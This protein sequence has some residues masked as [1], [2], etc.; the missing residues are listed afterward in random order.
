[1]TSKSESYHIAMI[2]VSLIVQAC[3]S[4]F[5]KVGNL[6]TIESVLGEKLHN[7]FVFIFKLCFG[8]SCVFPVGRVGHG[9]KSCS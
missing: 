4:G 7:I 5:G 9:L 1:M 2:P 3:V 6:V 8:E